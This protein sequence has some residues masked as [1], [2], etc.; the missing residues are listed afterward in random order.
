MTFKDILVPMTDAPEAAARAAVAADLAHR[1]GGTV[2]G[3][4]LEAR[5]FGDP[6][7]AESLT[8][9]S[10]DDI[11]RLL[12]EHDQ[13]LGKAAGKARAALEAA[14]AQAGAPCEW[15]TINGDSDMALIARARRA[16][17]TVLAAITP[18]CLAI[19]R[20]PVQAVGM[21]CG[22]PVLLVP[23]GGAPNLGRRVM[24]A[25]NGSRESA[26]AL[27][28]AWPLIE[29]ADTV[30][31]LQVAGPDAEVD[32][33]GLGRIFQ[34]HGRKVDLIVDRALSASATEILTRRIRD[35]DIDLLVMGLF[36]HSRVRE[37]VLGG[38]SQ[39]IIDAPP[40]ATLL[41]H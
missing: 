17:L 38:V 7:V 3:V 32:D 23:E 13:A 18:V 25:W 30:H 36:G 2:S 33:E 31:V 29:A 5:L 28:D 26:R 1:F 6:M 11:D 20:I 14:A 4:F 15:Q 10:P 34:R 21:A 41:S 19:R 12:A 40:V 8:Y 16:D 27:R 9:L 22:G 35:F 24:V 39:D 37:V